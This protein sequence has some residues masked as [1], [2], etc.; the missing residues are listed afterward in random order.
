MNSTGYPLHD[1][2]RLLAFVTVACE[3]AGLS[4]RARSWID[5]QTLGPCFETRFRDP[6][7]TMAL[8]PLLSHIGAYA[9][10][11][12]ERRGERWHVHACRSRACVEGALLEEINDILRE[13]T[14]PVG[15]YDDSPFGADF[16]CARM[17]A[18]GRP[19]DPG[20]D[21]GA[22]R[23]VNL[24]RYV[25]SSCPSSPVPLHVAT[26]L[27]GMGHFGTTPSVAE[28]TRN[29]HAM[30]FPS[31]EQEALRRLHSTALIHVFLE[32]DGVLPF[33]QVEIANW[34]P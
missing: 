31:L 22:C 16:L 10:G 4:D 1:G 6:E 20:A 17:A 34:N 18:F 25:A 19:L 26:E 30:S 3:T 2:D 27:L 11:I 21:G 12:V 7:E 13:H 33:V 15:L 5:S 24:S 23:L 14:G 29:Y 8:D 32:T 9:T 28:L